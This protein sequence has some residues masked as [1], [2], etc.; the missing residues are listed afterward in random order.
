MPCVNGDGHYKRRRRRCTNGH[1]YTPATT[2]LRPERRWSKRQGDWVT[3]SARVCLRCCRV[4]RKL[5]MRA[6]R[7]RQRAA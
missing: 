6:A 7:A 1:L 3:Y 2:R 5:W 4:W